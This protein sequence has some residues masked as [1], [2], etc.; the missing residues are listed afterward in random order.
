MFRRIM[1]TLG[2]HCYHL[3]GWEHK[4]FTYT[5]NGCRNG[6]KHKEGMYWRRVCCWCKYTQWKRVSHPKWGT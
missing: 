5:S 6:V 4:R 1:C 3:D 2:F